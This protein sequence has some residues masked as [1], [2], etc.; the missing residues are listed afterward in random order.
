MRCSKA[1]KLMSAAS[2]GELPADQHG[3]LQGHLTGCAACRSFE[4]DLT[5]LAHGLDSLL[6]PEPRWGFTDRL[7]ARLPDQGV[8]PAESGGWFG[9]LKPAPVGV[10]AVA[11]SLGVLLTLLVHSE[12]NGNGLDE[13][14]AQDSSNEYVAMLTEDPMGQLMTLLPGEED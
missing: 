5:S 1:R 4:T 7:L 6:S 8:R 3:L 12:A 14:G 9:F 10:G 11:F 13:D 2:D